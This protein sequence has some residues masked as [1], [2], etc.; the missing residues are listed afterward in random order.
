MQS[1]Q[2][3]RKVGNSALAMNFMQSKA[4]NLSRLWR[5]IRAR[6]DER[7]APRLYRRWIRKFDTL[8]DNDREKIRRRIEKFRLKP[9]ISVILPVYNVEEKW[10]RAC[11]DSVLRQLYENWQL[12]IADDFSSAPH[13]RRVLEEYARKDRRIKCVF[14]SSNGHISAASNSA[15]ALAEGEF[16]AMLDHDD[17]LAEHAFYAFVEEIN[18]FPEADLIYSDE[19]MIDETGAR[20]NPN[21]KPDFSRDLFYSLNLFT[22]LTVYRTEILRRIGGFRE[23]KEGSQDYDLAL[24]FTEEIPENHIR[25]IPQ[26]LYHWRA[27]SGSVALASSEK[28]Y[29]HERAREALREHFARL[30][31]KANVSRGFYEFHRVTYELPENVSVSLITGGKQKTENSKLKN[32]E[33]IHVENRS[34]EGFNAAVRQA[35]GDVLIFLD[36]DFQMLND[37]AFLELASF[38][39]QEKIG[40]VGAKILNEDETVRNGGIILGAN[41]LIGFAHQG[42]PKDRA[43]NL[44]RAQVVNNYS[45]VS[46]AFAVRRELFKKL[47]G[48]DA[49]NF[50][51]GLF[52]VDFCLRLGAEGFR[53]VFTPYAELLQKTPSSTEKILRLKNSAEVS[54]FKKKWKHEI[55]SDRFYNPNLSLKDAR[56]RLAFPPRVKKTF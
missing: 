38:A 33:T 19:D 2:R 49:K 31:V 3:T 47:G 9:L 53:T 42:L 44:Q 46:G 41:D 29:A 17:E 52:D 11:L 39:Q 26:I 7:A 28:S 27:I 55:E 37:G 34:A 35:R 14:R 12:C 32:F 13:V 48:F 54:N 43:G 6:L 23:G 8:T 4:K 40:A 21:F 45:A 22:H 25:H 36:G 15:L 5:K 20:Y 56:F 10:L 16:A 18:H 1:P 51:H 30:N 24:R 50:S